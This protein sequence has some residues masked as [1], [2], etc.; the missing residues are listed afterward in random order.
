MSEARRLPLLLLVMLASLQ[1]SLAATRR[2]Q[3]EDLSSEVEEVG[4]GEG[5]DDK[6]VEVIEDEVESVTFNGHSNGEEDFWDHVMDNSTDIERED[7]PREIGEK[8]TGELQDDEGSRDPSEIPRVLLDECPR[9]SRCVGRNFCNSAMMITKKRDNRL[10]FSSDRRGFLA[11]VHPPGNNLGVCC[12]DVEEIV[13]GIDPGLQDVFLEKVVEEVTEVLNSNA[14]RTEESREED[15]IS[16]ELGGE[17]FDVDEVKGPEGDVLFIEKTPSPE[18]SELKVNEDENKV[19]IT[20]R[21]DDVGDGGTAEEILND[22]PLLADL[23]PLLEIN[24]N[25]LRTRSDLAKAMKMNRDP[26]SRVKFVSQPIRDEVDY[27]DFDNDYIVITLEN[28]YDYDSFLRASR[29]QLR[30]PRRRRPLMRRRPQGRRVL[31]RG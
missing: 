8:E 22:E 18:E 9:L 17:E 1:L 24:L 2:R 29:G 21:D 11:C 3:I 12:M 31:I 13:K 14:I 10:T 7:V 19:T 20:L 16:V 28:D 30:T 4:E 25:V 6:A 15:V 23:E 27:L 5:A 26:K